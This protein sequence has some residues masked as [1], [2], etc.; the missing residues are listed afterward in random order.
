MCVVSAV[1]NYYRTRPPNYYPPDW[2]Y[3]NEPHNRP[4]PPMVTRDPEAM[5][6]LRK[7]VELLD[8]LDKKIG[9]TECDDPIKQDF[10]KALG[11]NGDDLSQPDNT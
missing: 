6:L 8:K 5:E 10:Y 1:S 4:V 3:Y 2:R 11:L 7:A 9:D